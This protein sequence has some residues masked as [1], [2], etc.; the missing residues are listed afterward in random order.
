MTKPAIILVRPQMGENI[1]AAARAMLN[2]G[3]TDLRLVAPRDGWPNQAATD[4]SSGALEHFK[5]TL[6]DNLNDALNDCHFSYATTA[7]SRELSKPSTTP[8]LAAQSTLSREENG[9]K[10]AFVFGPERTGLEN[11]EVSLCHE[12]IH[13]PTNPDFSSLNLAQSVL[14]VCYQYLNAEIS[15]QTRDMPEPATQKDA[16]DMLVRLEEELMNRNFFRNSDLK[17]TMLRNIR[18]MLLRAEMTDQEVRT[19]HGIISALI[20]N[21]IQD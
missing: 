7:R 9:Q 12:I 16:D 10:I 21:K 14:L 18:T 11:D 5:P 2:F 20:G 1:G 13:I 15:D 8:L 6:F 3:L 19:F 17:P 4:M